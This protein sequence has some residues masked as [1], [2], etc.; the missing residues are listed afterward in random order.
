MLSPASDANARV[1][2]VNRVANNSTYTF[3]NTITFYNTYRESLHGTNNTTF[4]T[5]SLSGTNSSTGFMS[6][7]P[8]KIFKSESESGSESE[9]ESE[10]DEEKMKQ[11]N[12]VLIT[13]DKATNIINELNKCK[14]CTKHKKKPTCFVPYSRTKTRN[15]Y[16]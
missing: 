12:I 7:Q 16:A 5:S 4:S 6:I 2:V 9:S 3:Y 8:L 14:C 13:Q 15:V 11:E 1:V 10:T